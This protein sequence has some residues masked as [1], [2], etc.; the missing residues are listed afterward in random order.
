LTLKEEDDYIWEVSKGTGL[1]LKENKGETRMGKNMPITLPDEK[2]IITMAQT[3]AL[4]T[5]QMIPNL[6]EQLDVIAESAHA[7]CDEGAAIY[8]IFTAATNR[9]RIPRISRYSRPSAM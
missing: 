7:C 4:V 8:H 2:V 5:K 1:S 3:G 6:P 9:A